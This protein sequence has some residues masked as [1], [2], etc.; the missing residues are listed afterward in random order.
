MT[1]GTS[2]FIRVAIAFFVLFIPVQSVAREVVTV[3]HGDHPSFSR[4]V[5]DWQEDVEYTPRLVAGRL[6]ITFNKAARPDWGSLVNDPLN[7]LA[8]PEYH[9]D[10]QSLIVSLKIIRPGKLSHFRYGT[11]I[12]FDVSAD[13]AGDDD[14]KAADEE[15]P[16]TVP[17][18]QPDGDNDII[19]RPAEGDGE[20]TVR[21]R[22]HWDSL[23]LSYPWE[24]DVRAAVFIRHNQLWVV[25]EGKKTVNQRDLEPFI[26]QRILSVRQLDHPTMTVLVY[27]VTAGQNVKVQKINR[28]WHID[29]KNS[30]TAP[31]R[32]IPSSHQRS[33]GSKGENFFYSVDN[34]GVVLMVED[35]V[36]GD[37]L[38]IIPVMDSSQGVLQ[39]QKFT[40]F[41]SLPTAQGIAVQLIAD[42][43]NILK[44]RNGISVAAREGL[45]LSPGQLSGKLGLIPVDGEV[46]DTTTKLVDFPLW[47]KGPLEGR[48]YHANK[49]E[50]LYMLANSTDTNRNEIRWRLAKFYL[51]NGRRREAFGV[52]NVMLDEDSRVIENP[53]FRTVLAVTNILMRRF[54]EGARLLV[55]K[56]LIGQQDVFL[57]RAVANSALGNHKLAF[58]NYKRGSDTLSLQAPENRI[59][60]LFAAIRSAYALG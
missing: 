58:E 1:M 27:Q 44:Y 46:E 48:D 50:L 53:E 4:I 52:L 31:S 16:A 6:E 5:F 26:G 33:A 37:E 40:E 38:A 9:I 12:A 35:P 36:I 41:T 59:A 28:Q 2:F 19:S 10:G 60:F 29:L 25:F 42:N 20:M 47:A 24:E 3:R 13:K 30:Q 49:H 23:R 57:W 45:V 54:D 32:S 56:A 34:A 22:R 14:I 39:L 15:A 43:I 8:E 18:T 17:V 11:K 55:H 21:V 7:F 51:A